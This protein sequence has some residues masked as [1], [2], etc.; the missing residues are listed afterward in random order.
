MTPA[1]SQAHASANSN[2]PPT[3][4]W[5]LMGLSGAFPPSL[6]QLGPAPAG[7]GTLDE[8]LGAAEHRQIGQGE[9][10]SSAAARACW[11]HLGTSHLNRFPV[12]PHNCSVSFSPTATLGLSE[13][14]RPALR[15]T[16]V[17][18]L[19]TE[20]GSSRPRARP[21]ILQGARLP[22]P[23]GTSRGRPVQLP[24]QRQEDHP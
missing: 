1:A 4:L 17:L 12:A 22:G 23:G 7:D 2:F 11:H 20:T 16:R 18:A 3:Q 8:A 13:T 15:K 5:A 21:R 10:S 19:D 9:V 6:K 14:E 24:A